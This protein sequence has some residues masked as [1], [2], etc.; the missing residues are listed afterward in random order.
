MSSRVYY[1]HYNE[2]DKAK[3]VSLVVESG[4]TLELKNFGKPFWRDKIKHF[5]GRTY[6][7]VTVKFR[8]FWNNAA[9]RARIQEAYD[10]YHRERIERENRQEQQVAQW[11]LRHLRLV[12]WPLRYLRLVRW[13]LRHLRSL[14]Y[15]FRY[16]HRYLTYQS[17]SPNLRPSV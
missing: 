12:R 15:S 2:E 8:V 17:R 10:R 5:P 1:S 16:L 3:I 9:F 13:T 14:R 7:A 11:P 6:K 4:H